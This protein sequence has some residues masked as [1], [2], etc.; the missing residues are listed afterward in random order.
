MKKVTDMASK[1]PKDSFSITLKGPYYR[2]FLNM[3]FHML[4][5]LRGGGHVRYSFI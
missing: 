1:S 4:A 2:V 3:Y 5:P